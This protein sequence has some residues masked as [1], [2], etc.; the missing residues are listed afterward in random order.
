MKMLPILAKGELSLVRKQP[1][2]TE[3]AAIS[4]EIVSL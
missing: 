4:S 2:A 3:E 1:L